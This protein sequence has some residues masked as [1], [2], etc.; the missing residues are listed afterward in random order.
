MKKESKA[1]STFLA[2]ILILA[3][4]IIGAFISYMWV[5]AAYY[6]MPENA[7]LLVVEDVA[8]PANNFTYFNVTILNPSNSVLDVNITKFSLTIEAKNETY[9]IETAEP[10]LPF[11]IRKATR[12]SFKCLKNWSNFAGETVR[13]EPVAENASTKSYP[14]TTTN[15]KLLIYN[16]DASE[17]IEYFNIT[18]QNSPESA[19]NLTI[20]EIMISDYS[21]NATPPLNQ[22]LAPSQQATFRC[23]FTWG[24]MIGQNATITVKTAEGFQQTYQ[25][26][27][28]PGARLYISSDVKFDDTETTYFNITVTS[29][30]IST[31]T[32][33]LDSVNLTL[34]DNST[35]KLDTIPPLNIVPVPLP[36]NQS[37]TL[38]CLWD[39]NTHRDETIRVNVYTKQGF[40]V[41]T[42][43]TVTPSAVVWNVDN[44][45]F[46]LAD[47]EHFSVN[48]TNKP[49][50]LYGINVT[51]VELN[52][53]LT[54]ID[55]TLIAPGGQATLVCGF[56]WSSLVG[57]N[58]TITV[59]G[60]YGSNETLTLY[61]LPLPLLKIVNTTFSNFELGNPYV[62]VTIY[63]SQFS[64][65][66]ANI[67]RVFVQTGNET[68]AI[69]GTITNPKISPN[70]YVVSAGTQVTV[71]CPWDWS[72]YLG[73]DVTVIAQPAE[74]LQVSM[75]L[76]VG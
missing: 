48:I 70:G 50:S 68:F 29:F 26:G 42:K 3:F 10:E 37:L 73:E 30:Q 71:I 35:I 15:A 55:S 18:V 9:S 58:A 34:P 56:N 69:D 32:A 43:T 75:T 11:L 46:D 63:H 59:H 13:I 65:F 45:K 19:I 49:V 1:I 2:I 12:Q 57:E 54:T 16:F 14:Y 74:G 67:T 22:T 33:T 25:T 47:V 17:N 40:D 23:D 7:T 39:W 36:A 4:M 62:N 53:N 72:P 5:M 28:I 51:K 64:K 31:A 76:K 60:V 61:S 24:T 27:N 21:V 20:S 52:Q 8:F 6:N 66:N 41:P 44:A 38:K